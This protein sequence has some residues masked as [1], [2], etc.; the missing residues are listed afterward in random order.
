MCL[1][2]K[3]NRRQKDKTFL[4]LLLGRRPGGGP[5]GCRSVAYPVMEQ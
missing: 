3:K 2:Q 5:C 1:P 4:L